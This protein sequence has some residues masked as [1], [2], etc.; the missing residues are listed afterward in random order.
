MSCAAC[1]V[2]DAISRIRLADT[3]RVQTCSVVSRSYPGVAV[4]FVAAVIQIDGG[5]VVRG[6]LRDATTESPGPPIGM[7][8]RIYIED[9]GQRDPGGRPFY[10]H[11]FRPVQSSP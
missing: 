6:T 8:V 11:V 3:G 4:P 9:T 2:G 1:G 7:P 10:S 5:G